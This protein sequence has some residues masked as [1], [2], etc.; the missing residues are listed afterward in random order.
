M[1]IGDTEVSLAV[2]EVIIG[3]VVIITIGLMWVNVPKDSA[4]LFK[5][6]FGALIA[7]GAG[8]A[9]GKNKETP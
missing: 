4:D 1:K 2:N 8:Y 3:A 6:G 9:M 5:Q 7:W